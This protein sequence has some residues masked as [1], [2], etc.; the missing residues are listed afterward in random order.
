MCWEGSVTYLSGEFGKEL[1][2]MVLPFW[3]LPLGGLPACTEGTLS[4]ATENWACSQ[5][6]VSVLGW[7]SL[8]DSGGV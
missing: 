3:D 1:S 8:A 4:P 2:P 6:V 7:E 5:P